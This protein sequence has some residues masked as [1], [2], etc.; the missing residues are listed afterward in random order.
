MTEPTPDRWTGLLQLH[1]R[2]TRS[3]DAGTLTII[4]REDDL[5]ISRQGQAFGS[6]ARDMFRE[7][8]SHPVMPFRSDWPPLE[9]NETETTWSMHGDL[10]VVAVGPHAATSF[11]MLVAEVNLLRRAI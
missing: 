7:W 6:V 3:W 10:L 11:V 8:L 9:D 1:I 2:N 4:V 5:V